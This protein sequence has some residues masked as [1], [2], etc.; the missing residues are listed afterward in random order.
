MVGFNSYECNVIGVGNS[1][2]PGISGVACGNLSFLALH[3]RLF[4]W[5]LGAPL[6]VGPALIRLLT[7]VTSTTRLSPP[8]CNQHWCS[9]LSSEIATTGL[10]YQQRS[11]DLVT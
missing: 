2:V 6:Q 11:R 1:Y 8:F 9:H 4:Q 7:C 10:Q 5:R 3:S